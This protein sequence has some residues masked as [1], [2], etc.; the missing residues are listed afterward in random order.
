MT[1]RAPATERLTVAQALVRFLAAQ[2]VERDG[3]ER[4]FFAGVFGIFGHG[5]VAGIGQALQQYASRLRYYQSRNEQAQVHAAAAYARMTNRLQTLACTSSVGPGATNMIT[6]AA[7]ATINR[8]PVLLLPGDVFATR[9][10]GTVLQQLEAGWS[11]EV[12]VNDAFRPVSRYWDRISRPE[13][14]IHAALEAMRVLTSQAETGAVTLALPQ[15][16]Q[17]E[18]FDWP[19]E[20]LRERTWHIPRPLPD[21]AALVRAVEAIRRSERPLIVAGG[22]VIYSE[23]TEALRALV[24]ATG[25]PVAETQAGKGSLS[26]DHPSSLGA[27]GAT[28]TPGA[29]RTAREAD[30]VIGIGTRYSDFTTASRTAFQ[31]RGRPVRQPQHRRARRLQARGSRAAGRRPGHARGPARR[32]SPAGAWLRPG[33]R[34]RRDT[35]ASGTARWSGSTGSDTARCSAR[36]K[37]WAPSTGA[38]RRGMWSYARPAVCRGT[39]TSCGGPGTPKATTSST[40]TP[41]WATRSPA[42]SG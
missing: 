5:N 6:G 41:A 9:R 26:F 8:L 19:A 15:D 27:M 12:S 11:Q 3:V 24:E 21:P 34:P 42:G 22:G 36:G 31:H 2:R 20:F 16:V 17:A 4:P 32:H 1:R 29:N 14:L 35:T 25:I 33:A 28:G 40:A 7:G 13:Q 39:C 37:S 18:A 38:P 30:L 10:V 23:A